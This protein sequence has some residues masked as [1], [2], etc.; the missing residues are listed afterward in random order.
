M[1]S[2]KVLFVA[3]VVLLDKGNPSS[4]FLVSKFEGIVNLIVAFTQLLNHHFGPCFFAFS[5]HSF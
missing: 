2:K 5:N 4:N 3:Q 1:E